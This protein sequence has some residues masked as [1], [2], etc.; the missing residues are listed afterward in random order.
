MLNSKNIRYAESAIGLGVFCFTALNCAVNPLPM[1][2]A[3]GAVIV[4]KYAIQKFRDKYDTKKYNEKGKEIESKY[5]IIYSIIDKSLNFTLFIFSTRTFAFNATSQIFR[6]A[7]FFYAETIAPAI[8]INISDQI[9]HHFTSDK[10]AVES[11]SES[12]AKSFAWEFSK[13][14]VFPVMLNKLPSVPKAL[15]FIILKSLSKLL[16]GLCENMKFPDFTKISTCLADSTIAYLS[17]QAGLKAEALAVEQQLTIPKEIVFF[18]C[19]TVIL[20]PLEEML[21]Y[22]KKT[23]RP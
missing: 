23:A 18:A 1:L 2:V 9:N 3:S 13:F 17:T 7:A 16:T 14:F 22:V 20:V 4:T 21:G 15:D 19:K 11:I 8:I 6:F 10:T 5:R 12:S